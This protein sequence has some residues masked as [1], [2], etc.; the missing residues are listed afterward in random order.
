MKKKRKCFE[1]KNDNMS[2]KIS[3]EL[4]NKLID[5]E[6]AMEIHQLLHRLKEPYKEVFTLSVFGKLS[7]AQIGEILKKS[8]SWSRL[9]YYRAKK[10][11]Q[12]AII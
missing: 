9:I 12:E 7:H 4:K 10:Q 11:L 2:K 5:D 6:G 8:A 3:N 1:H